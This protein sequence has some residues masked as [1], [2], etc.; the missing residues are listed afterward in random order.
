MIKIKTIKKLIG[1]AVILFLLADLPFAFFGGIKELPTISTVII[2]GWKSTQAPRHAMVYAYRSNSGF[3]NPID[4]APISSFEISSDHVRYSED[5]VNMPRLEC[6]LNDIECKID[7][8]HDIRIV[9]DDTLIYDVSNQEVS[10]VEGPEWVM[11][12]PMKWTVVSSSN[13]NSH[14]YDEKTGVGT[15]MVLYKFGRIQRRGI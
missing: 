15:L 11:G 13:I 12:G 8:K 9:V 5:T 6:H 2:K 3:V 14:Y 7:H 10:E 1:I 4:S